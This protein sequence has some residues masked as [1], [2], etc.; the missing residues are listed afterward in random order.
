[1]M[2][3]TGGS[4]QDYAEYSSC[5]PVVISLFNHGAGGRLKDASF[6]LFDPALIANQPAFAFKGDMGT[7]PAAKAGKKKI[8]F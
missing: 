6:I 1:M 5:G 4:P 3:G 8:D 7:G 2:I